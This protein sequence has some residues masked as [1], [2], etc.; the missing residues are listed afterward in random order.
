MSKGY[1]YKVLAPKE[2][3]KLLSTLGNQSILP[4]AIEQPTAEGAAGMYQTLVECAYSTDVQSVKSMAN[5][6][7]H[8]ELIHIYDE[9][10]NIVTTFELA[11]QLTQ[12]N[13]VSDFSFKDIWEPEAKR[14]RIVFSGII[15]FLRYKE[16]QT[17]ITRSLKEDVQMLDTRRLELVGN[18][19]GLEQELAGADAQYQEELPALI[20][21]E[22]DAQHA[23]KNLERVQKNREVAERANE[24]YEAEKKAQQTKVTEKQRFITQLRDEES[25]LQGQIAEDPQGLEQDIQDLQGTHQQKKACVEDKVNEKR[26]K[27]QRDQALGRVVSQLEGYKEVLDKAAKETANAEAA[28]A[29]LQKVRDDHSK[30]ISMQEAR[31][32]TRL[33]LEERIRSMQNEI[34]SSKSLHAERE[35]HIRNQNNCVLQQHQDLLQKR[36]KEQQEYHALQTEKEKVEA[37]VAS[38][39]RA[40]DEAMADMLGQEQAM[41]GGVEAYTQGIE[42]LL[43]AQGGPKVSLM[44]PNGRSGA[45]AADKSGRSASRDG[46]VGYRIACSPSPAKSLLRSPAAADRWMCRSPVG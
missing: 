20:A 6:P 11:K 2:I 40:H 35:Q 30:S 22:S 10:M 28:A 7:I 32:T 26:A 44:P 23:R 33:D 24:V 34:E 29:R 39:K 18:L 12:I 41:I 19:N 36:S 15:N 17:I 31:R 27:A 25:D 1:K 14:L 38:E 3:A 42:A 16:Q 46:Q 37:A 21:A 13:S 4:P 8:D 43:Q 5:L 45:E 9:A